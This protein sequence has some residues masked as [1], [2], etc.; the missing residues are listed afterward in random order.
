DSSTNTLYGGSAGNLYTIN[1]TTGL[2]TLVGA[3][4]AGTSFVNLGYDSVANVMYLT[5]SS[6]DSLYV[7]N[8]TTGVATLLGPLG[9]GYTNPQALA[10]DRSRDVLYVFDTGAHSL[11]ILDRATGVATPT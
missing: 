11:S 4:G 1:T 2:A 8:R 5:S 7:V 6:T 9:N 3:T 10:Y